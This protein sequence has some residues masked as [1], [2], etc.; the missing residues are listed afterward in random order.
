MKQETKKIWG[1]DHLIIVFLIIAA[2]G[3]ILNAITEEKFIKIYA[4]SSLFLIVIL[5][6]IIIY[7]IGFFR[8]KPTKRRNE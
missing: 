3:E 5:V 1:I 2:I 7:E 4:I 6:V 8:S